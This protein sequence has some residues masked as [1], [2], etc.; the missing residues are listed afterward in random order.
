MLSFEVPKSNF[1]FTLKN[2]TGLVY[3]QQEFFFLKTYLF[4][5]KLFLNSFEEV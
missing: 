2:C 5:F 3:P 1:V 4:I